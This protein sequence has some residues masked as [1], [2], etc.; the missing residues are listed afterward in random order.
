MRL[1]RLLLAVVALLSTG[2]LRRPAAAI[3]E[4]E[5]E[6]NIAELMPSTLPGEERP[7]GFAAR[8]WAL[9]P[10][11]GYA[12]DTSAL[13]GVKFAHR[14]LYDSGTV[15]DLD[16]TYAVNQQQ[17]IAFSVGSP[18]LW[19]RR[20]LVLLRAKYELDPQR[21]F[22]GL[23]NN[24]PNPDNDPTS[25]HEFQE[26]AAAI[27]VGYRPFERLAFNF[28]TGVRHVDIRRGRRLDNIPF[29]QDLRFEGGTL[30][31]IGGGVTQ[32]LA[33]SLVW[34]TRDD[35]LRPTRGWRLIL[36]VV[37]SNPV[38]SDFTFTRFIADGGYLRSTADRRFIAGLR[39]NGEWIADPA[40]D[41]PF[42]E[43]SELG[44]QD[45]L[46]GFYPHRFVGKG[47]ILVNGELRARLAE[48][49]FYDLYHVRLDGVLFGDGGRV[50]I[51]R[52]DLKSEFK[53]NEDIVG[54]VLGDFQ[55][56][57]GTGV[58]IVLSDAVVARIDAGFS[59]EELGLLYLSF[60][61]TF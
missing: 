29:T 54:R 47:R 30:P 2:L 20:F 8:E 9:L 32:P 13:F 4:L 1:V 39:V 26:T 35:F 17:H 36:K 18:K 28:S 12:P 22:F 50:F 45:T 61:H 40:R 27:T 60:G 44:G 25:T 33:L 31:G 38:L 10:Q 42:W 14:N 23:G 52:S 41:V 6:E 3:E 5:A 58:R 53:L 55:Y 57:A 7:F 11:F 48:F 24:E 59:A 21:D 37:G 49:D 16:A 51:D 34:N 56:D 15:M 43:L 46:R 19:D